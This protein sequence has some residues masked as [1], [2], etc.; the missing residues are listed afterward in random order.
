MNVSSIDHH[1]TDPLFATASS[2][3]QVWDENKYVYLPR[4]WNIHLIMS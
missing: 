2:I 4:Y 3:V 1:R